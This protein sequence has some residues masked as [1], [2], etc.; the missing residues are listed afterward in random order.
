MQYKETFEFIDWLAQF[1]NA[2]HQSKTDDGKIDG[3][4]LPKFAGVAFMSFAA[5]GGFASIGDEIRPFTDEVRSA[6]TD[7]FKSQLV[8]EG[9]DFVEQA[10]EKIVEGG[11][12][13]GDG[14]EDLTSGREV[15]SLS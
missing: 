6:L 11:L 3:K 13:L 14:L 5:F 4:D 15:L 9:G 10:I 7:R 1:A 2:I 8:F 12:L